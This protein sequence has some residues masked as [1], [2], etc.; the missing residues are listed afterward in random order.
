M[1]DGIQ[2]G[3]YGPSALVGIFVVLVFTGGLV[4]WRYHKALRDDRDKLQETVDK[5]ADQINNVIVPLGQNVAA[6]LR[7]LPRIDDTEP[8]R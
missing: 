4:P 3:E 7:A 2:I 6:I 1:F 5:Q 8:I